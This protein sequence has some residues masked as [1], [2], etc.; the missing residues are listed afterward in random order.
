MELPTETSMYSILENIPLQNYNRFVKKAINMRFWKVT[1][2]YQC[3]TESMDH[4][5][6]PLTLSMCM[7]ILD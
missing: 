1:E 5:I 4:R 7:A 2:T 6:W 3:N